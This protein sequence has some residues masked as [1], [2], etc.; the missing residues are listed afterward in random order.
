V[1]GDQPTSAGSESATGTGSESATGTGTGTG[2]SSGSGT[3]S[4]ATTDGDGKDSGCGCRS[5]DAGGLGWL[6]A[7]L[8][9]PLLRRRRAGSA[10]RSS[11]F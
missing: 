9:L 4:D 6:A 3:G 11:W 7:G 8:L 10:V 5:D 1:T 2:S